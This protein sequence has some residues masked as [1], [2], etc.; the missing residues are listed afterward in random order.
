MVLCKAFKNYL[1]LLSGDNQ[2]QSRLG[3]NVQVV[4]KLIVDFC[5]EPCLAKEITEYI[6]VKDSSFLEEKIS[7]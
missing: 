1:N 4:V 7:N 6:G 5:K 3:R 2:N